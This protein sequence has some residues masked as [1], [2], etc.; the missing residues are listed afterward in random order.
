LVRKDHHDGSGQRHNQADH[1]GGF[2][3]KVLRPNV[4]RSKPG[5]DNRLL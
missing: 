5:S 2:S 3:D 4:F 1:Q